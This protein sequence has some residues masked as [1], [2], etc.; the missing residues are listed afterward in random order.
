M[1]PG[2]GGVFPP[3]PASPPLPQMSPTFLRN[4]EDPFGRGRDHQQPANMSSKINGLL[5]KYR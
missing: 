5:A 2:M 4:N 3:G 1:L